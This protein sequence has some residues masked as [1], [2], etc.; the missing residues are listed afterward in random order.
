[1]SVNVLLLISTFF[2]TSEIFLKVRRVMKFGLM[3][4]SK[5]VY[6]VLNAKILRKISRFRRF[7][8][9]YFIRYITNPIQILHMVS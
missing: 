8:Y 1:M 5:F 2:A 7:I 3:T 6:T 9:R 4:K